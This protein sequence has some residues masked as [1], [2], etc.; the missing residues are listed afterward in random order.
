M[1]KY[2]SSKTDLVNEIVRMFTLCFFLK[3]KLKMPPKTCLEWRKKG[4]L[5]EKLVPV[6]APFDPLTL[7]SFRRASKLKFPPELGLS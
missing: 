3:S 7:G 2:S 6:L 5:K 1:R 4:N